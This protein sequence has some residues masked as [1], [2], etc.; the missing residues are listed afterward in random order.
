LSLR[1]ARG[2]RDPSAWLGT[3]SAIPVI[4][5]PAYINGRDCFGSG[6]AMTH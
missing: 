2:V 1:G 6:L 4:E 3:S 5:E